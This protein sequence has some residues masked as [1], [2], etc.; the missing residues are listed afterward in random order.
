MSKAYSKALTNAETI[1]QYLENLM[2]KGNTMLSDTSKEFQVYTI[3]RRMPLLPLMG[4]E[5]VDIE[6]QSVID[7]TEIYISKMSDDILSPTFRDTISKA[8]I[9]I[10]YII[11]LL[12]E[13]RKNIV[14]AA[15]SAPV[16]I[17]IVSAPIADKCGVIYSILLFMKK[18]YNRIIYMIL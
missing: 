4:N 2:G 8:Y 5:S 7:N 10:N 12:Q 6:L 14:A 9:R 1:K 18:Q 13:H 3:K 15:A 11:F 17:V 16:A